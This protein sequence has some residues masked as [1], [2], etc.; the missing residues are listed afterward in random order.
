MNFDPIFDSAEGQKYHKG[1]YQR[2][3]TT[4][5]EKYTDKRKQLISELIYEPIPK[6]RKDRNKAERGLI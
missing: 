5:Q 3:Q 6:C 2:N 4:M 1:I